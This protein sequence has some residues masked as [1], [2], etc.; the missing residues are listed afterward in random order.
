[1][2]LNLLDIA[3]QFRKVQEIFMHLQKLIHNMLAAWLCCLPAAAAD[4]QVPDKNVENPHYSRAVSFFAG[5]FGF[6]QDSRKQ[7]YK[8]MFQ[9]RDGFDRLIYDSKAEY[10]K[11]PE[12][13]DTD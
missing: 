11:K 7:A 8:T 3:G 4:Q 1:L 2:A 6:F 10:Y 12:S 5:I 13:E 9:T